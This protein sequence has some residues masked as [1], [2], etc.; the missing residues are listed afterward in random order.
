MAKALYGHL[1]TNEHLLRSEN[2]RLRARVAELQGEIERLSH[3]LASARRPL[4]DAA[5]LRLAAE[6][7]RDL[8]PALA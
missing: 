7:V 1:A 4:A 6:D 8:E 3:E 5:D 2:D